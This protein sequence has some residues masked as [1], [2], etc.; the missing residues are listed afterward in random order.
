MVVGIS[1][2]AVWMMLCGRLMPNAPLK[3]A[4]T[5]GLCALMWPLGYWNSISKIFGY[6]PMP[7]RRLLVWVLPLAIIGIWMYV[8][9]NRTLTFD[10][11]QQS[12]RMSAATRST[13]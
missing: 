13:P 7:P 10:T 12:R 2:I 11:Q 6:Q 8:L 1:T 5:A 4:L 3:S 9:N